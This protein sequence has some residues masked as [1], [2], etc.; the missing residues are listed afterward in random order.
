M[1]TSNPS[2]FVNAELLR[3]YVGR[4]V[5]A[6]I[7]VLSE[8]NGVIF[9]KSTDDNQ[10]TVK[11][12]PPFP[13]SKFVEVIG[14]ADTDKSIRADVWTNFGDSFDTSTF[15]QLCQLANGE[16]KHLFI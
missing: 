16:F 12:S 6:V 7:Q 10:I 14:I 2:V 13:L 8:G 3:L 15:N 9:G 1:D 4:R 5:R 11:G